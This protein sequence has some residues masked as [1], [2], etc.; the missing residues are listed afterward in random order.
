VRQLRETAQYP[1]PTGHD[2]CVNGGRDKE[3]KLTRPA[4]IAASQL[5][6]AVRPN[7]LVRVHIA[8]PDEFRG[9]ADL[10]RETDYAGGVLPSDRIVVAKS[11]GRLLGAYRLVREHDVLVLRGMRVRAALR[12]QGI[13]TRLLD[14]L[15]D[16]EE[17][18]YCVPHAYLEGFYGRAGFVSLEKA[19]MPPFLRTRATQYRAKGLDVIVM[20]R[21]PAA[22]GRPTRCSR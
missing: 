4:Q 3:M 22:A 12:R 13:G 17:P 8:S 20:K 6:P 15:Q 16:I 14:A 10:Y 19:E 1:V 18:C 7:M 5:I 9:V 11:D 21:E 2:A